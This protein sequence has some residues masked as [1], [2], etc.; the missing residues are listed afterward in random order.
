MNKY[1]IDTNRFK[2]YLMAMNMRESWDHVL[3]ELGMQQRHFTT[4][5]AFRP[6]NRPFTAQALGDIVII[7]GPSIT[8]PR[9]IHYREFECVF[10]Y[11]DDYVNHVPGIRPMIRDECGL[12]S[13]YIITLIHEYR[14]E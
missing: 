12:N 2:G 9:T 11:Y 1:L 13:S 8:V 4:W 10:S 7:D 6:S 3:T 5:S 14:R